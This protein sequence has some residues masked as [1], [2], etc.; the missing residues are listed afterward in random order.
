M[1]RARGFTLIELITVMALL[2]ILAAAVMPRMNTDA[3]HQAVFHDRVLAALRYAQK[4]AI[5]HRRTVCVGFG[6]DLR[7]LTLDMNADLSGRCETPLRIPGTSSNQITSTHPSAQFFPLPEAFVFAANGTTT[8]RN[9][10]FLDGS[11][12]TIIGSTGNVV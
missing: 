4:T 3:Y 9:I 12:I 5:S 10:G 11:R 6:D 8:H 1:R 2:G 7:S